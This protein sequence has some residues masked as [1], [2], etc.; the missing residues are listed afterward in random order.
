MGFEIDRVLSMGKAETDVETYTTCSHEVGMGETGREIYWDKSKDVV[1]LDMK[2]WVEEDEAAYVWGGKTGVRFGKM[3][4]VAMG[5]ETLMGCGIGEY[6]GW[7][8]VDEML[9]ANMEGLTKEEL[10]VQD[11]W[12]WGSRRAGPNGYVGHYLASKKVVAGDGGDVKV[13][14]SFGNLEELRKFVEQGTV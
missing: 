3:G 12:F 13:R 11:R 8:G 1:F 7:E 2:E 4:R 9:V 5:F 14:F 6:L 10:E